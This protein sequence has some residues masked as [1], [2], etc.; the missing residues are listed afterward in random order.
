MKIRKRLGRIYR[1][2]E[3]KKKKKAWQ[4]TMKNLTIGKCTCKGRR[5]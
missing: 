5:K 4:W 2:D 1:R 3:E